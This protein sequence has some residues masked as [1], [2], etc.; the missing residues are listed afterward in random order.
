MPQI[1]ASELFFS[2]FSRLRRLVYVNYTD[3]KS[4]N[5][6]V[7]CCLKFCSF[8]MSLICLLTF[9]FQHVVESS[10]P[11]S[12]VICWPTGTRGVCCFDCWRMEGEWM[13]GP[14]G[15]SSSCESWEHQPFILHLASVPPSPPLTSPFSSNQPSPLPSFFHP[16]PL[17]ISKA[18]PQS[19]HHLWGMLGAGL[20]TCLDLSRHHCL[21]VLS[22]RGRGRG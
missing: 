18:L 7:L 4:H 21:T 22:S 2:L 5:K 10:P 15:S 12:P 16:H 3:P 6:S 11:P 13:N 9:L 19:P 1:S 8:V 14:T 17:I 20:C